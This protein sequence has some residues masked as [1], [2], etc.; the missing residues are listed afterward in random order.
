MS[1]AVHH[2]PYCIVGGQFRAMPPLGQSDEYRCRGCGH[3]IVEGCPSHVC[4][5]SRCKATLVPRDFTRLQQEI[6]QTLAKLKVT[7][8]PMVRLEVLKEMRLLLSEADHAPKKPVQG[9]AMP[10]C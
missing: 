4:T 9:I 10:E 1:G 7:K 6:E 5:C 3:T 2:C 8:D